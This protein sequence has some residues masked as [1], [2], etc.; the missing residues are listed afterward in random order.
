MSPI[1]AH[2]NINSKKSQEFCSQK[3]PNL[4]FYNKRNTM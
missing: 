3:P 4:K 2:E 1:I